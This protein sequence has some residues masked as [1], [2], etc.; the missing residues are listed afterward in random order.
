MTLTL[1]DGTFA[2]GN[3]L[4]SLDDADEYH[5]IR[6]NA[7][8]TEALDVSK[9]AA[10]VRAF[11]YLAVQDWTAGTFDDGIPAAITKAQCIGAAKELSSPGT[12]QPDVTTGIKS[13]SIAGAVEKEFFE[14]GEQTIF[15]AIEN[16]IRPYLGNSYYS[17][18]RV[19][20]RG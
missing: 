4:I 10:L 13:Q 12:L 18:G 14:D 1:D 5:D 19:L 8:W 15:S 20:V 7:E 11:D 2:V 9:E 3:T 17:T 6:G 16:L